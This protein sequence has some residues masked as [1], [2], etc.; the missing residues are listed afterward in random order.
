MQTAF[1]WPTFKSFYCWHE[2]Y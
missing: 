2:L 1:N